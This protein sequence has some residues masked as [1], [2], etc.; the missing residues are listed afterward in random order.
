MLGDHGTENMYDGDSSDAL[1]V[2]SGIPFF[3]T[4]TLFCFSFEVH[5][6]EMYNHWQGEGS[7]ETQIERSPNST[8]EGCEPPRV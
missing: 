8:A 3:L 7:R 2:V 6:N 1:C 5:V 4:S